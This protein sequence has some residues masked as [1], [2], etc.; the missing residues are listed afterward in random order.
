MRANLTKRLS[1]KSGFVEFLDYF[2]RFL[3]LF[4]G[5]IYVM[6]ILTPEKDSKIDLKEPKNRQKLISTTDSKKLSTNLKFVDIL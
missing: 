1:L 2:G 5:L 3:N 6:L 4:R